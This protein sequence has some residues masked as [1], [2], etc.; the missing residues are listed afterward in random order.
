MGRRAGSRPRDRAAAALVLALGQRQRPERVPAREA[1]ALPGVAEALA[2]DTG[3]RSRAAGSAAR[4]GLASA[5]TSD[6]STSR[7]STSAIVSTG[8]CSSA[9]TASAAGSSKPPANT[10]R[11][12]SSTCSGTV[13]RS[14]LHCS[15][16]QQGL[17]ARRRR[18]GVG[19]QQPEAVVQALRERAR[20]QPPEPR[21][22]PARAPAAGRRAGSRCAPRPSRSRA[23]TAKPGTA[24]PRA[25]RE[26]AHGLVA[27]QLLGGVAALGIRDRQRRHAEHDLAVDAQRLARGGED[28]Q[29]RRRP[30]QLVAERRAGGA[31]GARS[32][33]AR[34]ARCARA[35][36]STIACSGER[37]GSDAT[38][39]AAAA[40]CTT[41]LPSSNAGE[42]HERGSVGVL[43]LAAARE[44]E[45]QPCLAGAT[46]AGERQQAGGAQQRGQLAELVLAP[47]ERARV[48]R[49]RPD[50]GSAGAQS[51]RAPPRAR[52]AAPRA[53]HAAPLPSPR[54][55]SPAAARLRRGQRRAV[56]ARR[57]RLA[58]LGRAALELVHVD[59]RVQASAA[60][61]AA[62]SR[63][64]PSTRRAA[65]TTWLRLFA[66]AAGSRSGH[67]AYISCSRCMRWP[68]ARAS[69]LTR[70]R[71][72]RRRHAPSVERLAGGRR[73]EAAEQFDRD[74]DH[75][76]ELGCACR[77]HA[78][79]GRGSHQGLRPGRD[80]DDQEQGY[81]R[82][83]LR[84][85][86]LAGTV[87]R[88][89]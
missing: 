9:H 14:W 67:S 37:P 54:S 51:R 31:A 88:L 61:R 42:L 39:N 36:K 52:G 63:A 1:L 70:S 73:G 33:R 15:V 86:P 68:G 65:C 57:A 5:S 12:R 66:A 79:P 29:R 21:R 75:R 62:R 3:A 87:V 20:T 89:T 24:A 82:R 41:R 74:L 46:G 28:R 11:R 50:R 7:A 2:R 4:G 32:C 38:S 81:P 23:S 44:L 85:S 71:P 22:R 48:R 13:S 77:L 17:L 76:G 59:A 69:I 19:A 56:G 10:A 60:P 16:A 8:S 27:H 43:A 53:S 72:L 18:A 35:R 55:G 26:Q 83:A 80:R 58:G 40:A 78:S 25:V 64:G 47:D 30:Q 84:R 45:R 6:F 34:A 49:E